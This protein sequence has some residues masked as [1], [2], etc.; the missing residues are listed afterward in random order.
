MVALALAAYLDSLADGLP[1]PEPSPSRGAGVFDA[2]CARCHAPPGLTGEP[3]ALDVVGTDPTL[4]RSTERTTGTYRVPSLHGVATRGP[5]LHD[6]TVPS[7]DVL[8]DPARVQAGFADRLHG[9]GPVPGHLFGL[10][11]PDSDRLAL[12]TYLKTL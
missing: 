12:V 8:F 9:K 10:D 4:G 5:L 6:G 11:L 2:N 3:V 7:V 1:A